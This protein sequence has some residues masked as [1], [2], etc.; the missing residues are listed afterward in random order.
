MAPDIAS[1]V[2]KAQ[3]SFKGMLSPSNKLL[4]ENLEKKINYGLLIKIRFDFKKCYHHHINCY[5]RI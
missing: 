1:I 4:H 5:M 2:R 3:K